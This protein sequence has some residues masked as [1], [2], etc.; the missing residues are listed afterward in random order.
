MTIGVQRFFCS[1]NWKITFENKITWGHCREC[2]APRNR[3]SFWAEISVR[4]PRKLFIFYYL[5]KK[6]PDQSIQKKHL[7]LKT[8]ALPKNEKRSGGHC[9]WCCSDFVFKA[10][11]HIFWIL[12]SYKCFLIINKTQHHWWIF[13]LDFIYQLRDKNSNCGDSIF[14]K[15]N[16]YWSYSTL[17][18]YTF[19]LIIKIKFYEWPNPCISLKKSMI[20]SGSWDHFGSVHSFFCWFLSSFTFV[21]LGHPFSA[22]FLAEIS[23]RSPRKLF[24][25][26]IM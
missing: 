26:F 23:A 7:I 9:E 2:N 14:A 5:D 8:E 19:F 20:I 10:K 6:I 18:W 16:N 15:F 12:S 24:I 1:M 22:S 13:F 11:S 25:Y 4:S 21:G 3:V 17:I